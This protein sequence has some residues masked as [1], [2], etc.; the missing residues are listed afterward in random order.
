MAAK[1]PKPQRCLG[2]KPAVLEP[3][4]IR[5]GA[6]KEAEGF[7]VNIDPRTRRAARRVFIFIFMRAHFGLR[8]LLHDCYPAL[9]ER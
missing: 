9:S 6:W 7:S 2:Q 1:Q 4:D 8:N 3:R 5:R